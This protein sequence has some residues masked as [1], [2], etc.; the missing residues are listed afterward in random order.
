MLTFALLVGTLMTVPDKVVISSSSL[1]NAELPKSVWAARQG[2]RWSFASGIVTGQPSTPEYQASRKDHKG[3]EPRLALPATPQDFAAE[4]DVQ[5]SG[6]SFSKLAPFIEFGH[7]KARFS[8]TKDALTLDADSGKA[9]LGSTTKMKFVPEHWYRV[10]AEQSGEDVLIQVDGVKLF[11][12]HPSL[13][14]KTVKGAAGLGFCGTQGGKLE[15][16]NLIVWSVRPDLQPTWPTLRESLL[17]PK[18]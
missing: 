5:F 9:K 8:F 16:K 14:E 13:K 10:V 15:L 18:L 6:G 12:T 4:F 17:S 3:T 1:T 11:G 7:H 2:T